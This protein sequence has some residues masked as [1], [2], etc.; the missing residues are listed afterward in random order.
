MRIP[1]LLYRKDVEESFSQLL[2]VP[3]NFEVS[4]GLL[5]DL[6]RAQSGKEMEEEQSWRLACC[7]S[8]QDFTDHRC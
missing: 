7:H 2:T 4:P 5:L 1:S 6:D 3:L 8:L